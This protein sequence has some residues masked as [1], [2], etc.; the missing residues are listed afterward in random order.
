[1]RV[2][3]VRNAVKVGFV[4]RVEAVR[5]NYEDDI[6]VV[7]GRNLGPLVGDIPDVQLVMRSFLTCSAEEAAARECARQEVAIDT[8]EGARLFVETRDMVA[9]RNQADASRELDPVVIDANAISYWLA[10]DALDLGYSAAVEGRQIA[11][12]TTPFRER[13]PEAPRQAMLTEADLMFQGALQA[14]GVQR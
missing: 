8:S 7:D 2:E 6:L 3:E 11:F 13:Y 9:R 14:V 5:D 12:N 1:A 10:G 4:R